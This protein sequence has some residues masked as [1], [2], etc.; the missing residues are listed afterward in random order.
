MSKLDEDR[1]IT[2]FERRRRRMLQNFGISM[3]LIMLSLL[4]REAVDSFPNLFGMSGNQWYAMAVAQF[5]A[6]V[7]FALAGLLQYRC[8]VCKELIRGHDKYYLGVI[9]SP[10]RCPNCGV[11]L[12]SGDRSESSKKAEGE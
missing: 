12:S 6:A 7:V 3:L 4:L 8:P 2:E 9:V 5:V 1:I 11:K 10:S